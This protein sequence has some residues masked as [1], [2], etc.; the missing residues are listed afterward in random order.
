[1]LRVGHIVKIVFHRPHVAGTHVGAGVI[2]ND[3]NI[4]GA[5]RRF[6]SGLVSWAGAAGVC[7]VPARPLPLAGV[8]AALLSSCFVFDWPAPSIELR[9][10]AK[11]LSGS[12]EF[13]PGVKLVE[14]FFR[15]VWISVIISR[16]TC[17]ILPIY[18]VI[19]DV[20]V[21]VQR[22]RIGESRVTHRT[23]SGSPIR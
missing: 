19:P 16:V 4:L 12:E 1:M 6:G 7:A 18:R 22:L 9:E 11:L 3:Q 13:V 8:V 5:D 10:S 15:E 2:L 23:R 20:G 17:R 21:Q 14:R